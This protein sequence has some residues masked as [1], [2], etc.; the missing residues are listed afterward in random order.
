MGARKGII[1]NIV[2]ICG[3]TVGNKPLL[4]LISNKRLL[5]ENHN[6]VV[7]YS[8]EIISINTS[9]GRYDIL[10]FELNLKVLSDERLVIV[11]NISGISI[12]SEE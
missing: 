7:Q 2:E 1:T 10:G 6:G 11:G 4:E 9:I 8:N 3:G 5:I 12:L